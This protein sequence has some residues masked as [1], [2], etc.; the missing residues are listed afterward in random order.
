M[1]QSGVQ[2]QVRNG[3]PADA[4]EVAGVFAASWRQAYQG[5]IPQLHLDT[6]IQRRGVKWWAQSL[7]RDCGIAVIDVNGDIAGYSTF[8]RSRRQGK[9]QGEIFELYLLPDYQGVGLGESLFEATRHKLD[10]LQLRGV[11]LW[12]LLDNTR[13]CDFY[14]HRGGRP[15]CESTQAFGDTELPKVAFGWQ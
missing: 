13:A 3:K 12:A 11:M 5:I 4:E 2:F 7:R 6:I 9:Y 10:L 14:W 8:G 15:L 1:L